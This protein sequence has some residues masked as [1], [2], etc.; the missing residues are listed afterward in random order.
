MAEDNE[1]QVRAHQIAT[2]LADGPTVAY[3]RIKRA[4]GESLSNTLEEQLELEARLQGEL[5]ETHDFREGVMAFLEKRRA[6]FRGN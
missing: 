1:L 5:G 3:A 2:R 4:L 6:E